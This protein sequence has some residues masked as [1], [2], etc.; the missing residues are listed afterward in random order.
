MIYCS[1][2]PHSTELEITRLQQ[3]ASD[4]K[5]RIIRTFDSANA[6]DGKH[7]HEMV[8][9]AA[10]VSADIEQK[11]EETA[12]QIK[13][14]EAE[15]DHCVAEAQRLETELREHLA[16]DCFAFCE[17]LRRR[18]PRELCILIFEALWGGTTHDITDWNIK[19]L[20]TKP[21]DPMAIVQSW[22]GP[23][24]LHCFEERFVGELCD[25]SRKAW[26]RESTFKIKPFP[27]I[28]LLLSEEFWGEPVRE[29]IRCVVLRMGYRESV[30]QAVYAA[31]NILVLRAVFTTSLTTAGQRRNIDADLALMGYFSRAT[32]I[33]LQIT[34]WKLYEYSFMLR[35][36]TNDTTSKRIFNRQLR[37]SN[38][39]QAANELFPGLGKLLQEGYRISL[40][41]DEN[42]VLDTRDVALDEASWE[43]GLDA[44]LKALDRENFE[45]A[46]AEMEHD[47]RCCWPPLLPSRKDSDSS[48]NSDKVPLQNE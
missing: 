6:P 30:N 15:E 12:K 24:M 3:Q 19:D 2:C 43:Q 20:K 31:T 33:K 5:T 4:I 28:P 26:W 40:V 16:R 41:I 23:K 47:R 48:C 25:E 29:K 10:P 38:F 22:S 14:L 17:T 7:S 45:T 36:A 34:S 44:A 1:K 37:R 35:T 42:I 8:K 27:L 11:R 13:S 46:M 9:I 32:G 21:K 18:L 39:L